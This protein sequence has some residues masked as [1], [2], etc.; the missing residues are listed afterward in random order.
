M[1]KG[2][3]GLV[4]AIEIFDEI[5]K[6]MIN[7]EAKL[8]DTKMIEMQHDI[9]N[10]EEKQKKEAEEEDVVMNQFDDNFVKI[11]GVFIKTSSEN[12]IIDEEEIDEFTSLRKSSLI[13]KQ[14]VPYKYNPEFF[15]RAAK[16]LFEKVEVVHDS[17]NTLDEDDLIINIEGIEVAYK[18]GEFFASQ[19]L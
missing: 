11:E 13:Q 9:S 1:S 10:P 19:C 17:E 2:K 5:A 14:F 12:I 8:I 6:S 18:K 16:D 7:E 4:T 3:F 15:L